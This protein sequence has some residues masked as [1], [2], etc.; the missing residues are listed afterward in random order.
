MG[1]GTGAVAKR[2]CNFYLLLG[3]LCSAFDINLACVGVATL[4]SL[5]ASPPLPSLHIVLGETPLLLPPAASHMK[6]RYAVKAYAVCRVGE[7][8]LYRKSNIYC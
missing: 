2:G 5:F 4:E 7:W 1:V 8:P 3:A 6:T